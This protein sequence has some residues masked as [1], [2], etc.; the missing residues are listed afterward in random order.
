MLNA[1]LVNSGGFQNRLGK[2]HFSQNRHV[3]LA[4]KQV[5]SVLGLLQFFSFYPRP[6]TCSLDLGAFHL[7]KLDNRQILRP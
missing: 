6:L 2:G 1:K 5:I 3:D 4:R 7:C